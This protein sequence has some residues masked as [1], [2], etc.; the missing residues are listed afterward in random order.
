MLWCLIW[1]YST[2][3]HMKNMHFS[4]QNWWNDAKNAAIAAFDHRDGDPSIFWH[5]YLVQS[6]IC[7]LLPSYVPGGRTKTITRQK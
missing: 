6:I 7:W 1:E 5:K 3:N 2:T 4:F